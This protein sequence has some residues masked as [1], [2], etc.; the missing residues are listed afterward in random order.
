MTEVTALI[1][2][3]RV[4]ALI[5]EEGHVKERIES[6]L[7]VT[8]NVNSDSGIVVIQA[9]PDVNPLSVLR[10]K[11]VVTAIARGFPPEK[12]FQLFDEDIMLDVLSLRDIFGKSESD[13]QRVKGRVIGREGKSR[14]NIEE[15]TQAQLSVFGHTI[16]II[17]NY[18]ALSLARE[19]VEM[20]IKG[21]Q[22][23]TVYEHLKNRR[24][25]IKR[26]EK[27]ELWEKTPEASRR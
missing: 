27:V 9:D 18:D 3:D 25:E 14:R 20:L 4:G 22:H 8:L 26:K 19:G 16:G 23:A 11:D 2:K 15:I 13:I 10:A 6:S 1:S 24:R 17:G 12:A 21:R 7:H 5:G